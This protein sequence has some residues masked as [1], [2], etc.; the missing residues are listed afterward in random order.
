MLETSQKERK[1][2]PAHQKRFI[3]LTS[4]LRTLTLFRTGGSLRTHLKCKR[5]LT[6]LIPSLRAGFSL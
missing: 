1:A 2:S 3:W 4:R 6:A 5:S